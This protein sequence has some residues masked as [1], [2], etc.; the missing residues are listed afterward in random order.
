MTEP[1]SRAKMRAEEYL[2]WERQQPVRHEFDGGEV[3]AMAGGSPRHNALC[4]AIVGDL[5]A[6][7]RGGDCRV[8]TSDQRV[9]LRFQ[10]KYVYPDA[11]VVCGRLALEE[12]TRDVVKNPRAVFEVLSVSTEAHDRGGKWEGYRRLSSLEDYVLVAQRTVSVEHYQRQTDGSWRY[13]VAGPGESVLLANGAKLDIDGIYEDV[14][15]LPG[16]EEASISLSERAP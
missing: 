6:I 2:A 16:D 4:A 15:D 7:L 11:T 13:T 3:F 14:F 1:A 12:G 5:R 8:L 9:S 10:E